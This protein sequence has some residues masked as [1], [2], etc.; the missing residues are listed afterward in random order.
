MSAG[1]TNFKKIC[2]QFFSKED[3]DDY[4]QNLMHGQYT[5][6]EEGTIKFSILY[7]KIY[8]ALSYLHHN[9]EKLYMGVFFITYIGES[10]FAKNY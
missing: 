6:E 7:L 2:V 8:K 10:N 4:I 9:L 1:W 3:L 5:T